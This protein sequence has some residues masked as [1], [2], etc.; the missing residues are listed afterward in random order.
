MKPT[1]QDMNTNWGYRRYLTAN[2]DLIRENNHL[3]GQSIFNNYYNNQDGHAP[4]VPSATSSTY[5]KPPPEVGWLA[6]ASS[7]VSQS[8]NYAHPYRYTSYSD[9]TSVTGNDWSDLHRVYLE[10][11]E[12]QSR[13]V[14]PVFRGRLPY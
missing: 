13:L 3:F 10:K 5:A 14:A 4:F 8:S 11:E 2:A 1:S 7:A 9:F 12:A 6:V